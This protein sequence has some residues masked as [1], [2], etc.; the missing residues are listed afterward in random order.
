MYRSEEQTLSAL[1]CGVVAEWLLGNGDAPNDTR[2]R[3]IPHD[4]ATPACTITRD[5]VVL[6]QCRHVSCVCFSTTTTTFITASSAFAFSQAQRFAAAKTTH[7]I[8]TLL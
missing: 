2:W 7:H 3:R 1:R 5:A 8:I 6:A 4:T